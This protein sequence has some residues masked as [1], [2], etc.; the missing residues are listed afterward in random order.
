APMWGCS[1]ANAIEAPHTAVHPE[2]RAR[3]LEAMETKLTTGD[4]DETYR[5]IHADETVRWI[6]AKTF[7]VRDATGAV[8][9]IVGV[10]ED[11]TERINLEA[12]FLRA[13][14]LE[15]IGTLAGG[16]AHDLNNILAPMLMAACLMKEG[17]TSDRDR[18]MLTMIE[19]SARRG[20]DI[21]RQLLTFSRG[22]EG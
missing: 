2:D 16:V 15:A 7:P 11:V 14:R 22:I 6:R 10:A 19:G 12:Q 5:I 20:A 18:D 3:V 17:A 13:R 8:S 9:R 21:I 4:Y 1:P